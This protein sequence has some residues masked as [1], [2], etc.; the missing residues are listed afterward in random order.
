MQS[1]IPLFEHIDIPYKEKFAT[2]FTEAFTHRSV[3]N[4][5]K[6]KNKKHN[7]RLEFLGDAVLELI[8]TEFLFKKFNSQEG[9]LTNF[10]SA[11]VKKENL[12]KVARK[13]NLGSYLILSRGEDNSGGRQKDYLLA[14]L[15]EAFIGAIYICYRFRISEKFIKTFVLIELDEI[16]EK[17]Y[18]LEAKS[19]F[20]EFTQAEFGITPEYR[21]LLAIGL[22][23]EKEF[24]MGVFLEDK[25]VGKGK[26]YSKKEAQS[27]AAEDALSSKHKWEKKF[28][29]KTI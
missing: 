8:A 12:A 28:P 11:L 16:I 2:I 25:Q 9:E 19:Q 29:R 27:N 3:M 18:H 21:V 1:L 17:G 23:H 7:E 22:D 24:E 20:Q 15:L 4:E 26:G 14:N 10:R 6:N 13:L 5:G